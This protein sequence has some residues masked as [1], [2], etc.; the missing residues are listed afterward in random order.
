MEAAEPGE[1]AEID[2][3][4]MSA[5]AIEATPAKAF[6]DLSEQQVLRYAEAALEADDHEKAQAIL[7]K[8]DAAQEIDE[9]QLEDDGGNTAEEGEENIVTSTAAGI[10]DPFTEDETTEDDI[11]GYYYD[12]A[13]IVESLTSKAIWVVGTFMVVMAG[14]F[15]WLYTGGIGDVTDLFFQN[16]P[17]DLVEEPEIVV[18]HPVEALIFMLKFS[19]LVGFLS[20]VPIVLYLA[21]PAIEERGISSGGDRSILL[22]WGGTLFLVLGGGTALGFLYI[23]PTV[24]SLLAWDVVNA[25]MVIAYRISSFGW[26]IVY[27]TVG[28]GVL[29]MIPTT[30]VMFHHGNIVPYSRMRESW[31]GVVLA[32]FALAG[33]FSPSGIFTMFI[34]A[35]PASIAYLLGLGL[36]WLYT[37]IGSATRVVR[38]EAAD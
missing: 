10:L 36:L 1:R 34:V 18:L 7:D 2:V 31:R 28:V 26:L 13:F 11:G 33:L 6:L 21:W 4:A 20:I 19:T 37:R 8:Y 16:M 3:G 35:I 14:T 27:L 24:I 29:T 9:S 38:G 12:I 15:M 25:N 22:Y 32:L 30:M 23:A 5:R 17:A